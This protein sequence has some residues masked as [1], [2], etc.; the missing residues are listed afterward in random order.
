MVSNSGV[1]PSLHTNCHHQIIYA[2][3]NFKIFF[4]PPYERKVWHYAKANTDAIRISINNIDWD[5][6]FANANVNR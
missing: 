6:L 3:I 2:H 1:Y 5:R 4:P